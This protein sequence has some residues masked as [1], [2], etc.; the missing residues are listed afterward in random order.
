LP[1]KEIADRLNQTLAGINRL[2]NSPDLQASIGSLNQLLRNT[3]ALVNNLNTEIGP[4][5]SDIKGA[6]NATRGAF[7]QAE[8]TLR[9][10][11][12]A[13]G[14]IASSIKETLASAQDTLKETT[15]AVKTI[16]VIAM[17]NANLGYEVGRTLAQ[18]AEL[19]RSIR[20]LADYLE[21]HPEALLRG[22]KRPGKG[23]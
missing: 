20:I 13:P 15:K 10:D 5:A 8:K 7:A 17:Q 19:S 6:V 1:L 21:R 23:E 4:L 3:D 2:V 22:K 14:Q 18:I 9:F 16:N 12:G 11:E